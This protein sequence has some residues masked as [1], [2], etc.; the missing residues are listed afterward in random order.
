[1]V[2]TLTRTAAGVLGERLASS[3]GPNRSRCMIFVFTW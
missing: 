3:N 1:M 2:Y